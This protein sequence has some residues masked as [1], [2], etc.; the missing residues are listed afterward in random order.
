MSRT[1]QTGTTTVEFAIV[2]LLAMVVLFAVI[3]FG[4]LVFVVNALN[5]ATRRGARMAVVCPINDPAIAQVAVFNAP[6]GSGASPVVGGLTT[7]NVDIRYLNQAGLPV[8]SPAAN[9]TQIHYVQVR[10]VNFQHTLV[11]PVYNLTFTLPSY[12]TTMP[13]ESL[14]IPRVGAGPLPC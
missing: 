7:S 5:E 1:L 2:G 12:P 9:F 13:R 10:I 14:G 11:I 3:E 6:G 4:R 8:A